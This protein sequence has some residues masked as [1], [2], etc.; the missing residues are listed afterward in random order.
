MRDGSRH[1]RNR[2]LLLLF[3]AKEVMAVT[4]VPEAVFGVERSALSSRYFFLQGH[5][6][7][8]GAPLCLQAA[9][10]CLLKGLKQMKDHS[11]ISTQP[12]GLCLAL[13]SDLK[14]KHKGRSADPLWIT[15]TKVDCHIA[16]TLLE[17]KSNLCLSVSCEECRPPPLV[18]LLGRT[19]LSAESKMFYLNWQILCNLPLILPF[20]FSEIFKMCFSLNRK[21]HV[22]SVLTNRSKAIQGQFW[23]FQATPPLLTIWER[24]LGLFLHL[25]FWCWQGGKVAVTPSLDGALGVERDQCSEPALEKC[26]SKCYRR[27]D[28]QCSIKLQM[29]CKPDNVSKYSSINK[30]LAID[31][32]MTDVSV[33]IKCAFPK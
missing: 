23:F 1:G 2:G 6:S 17:S 33:S 8:L 27:H 13:C 29:K 22:W 18:R 16:P 30:M 31:L 7:F 28:L 3:L 10:S 21:L 5:N 11:Q 25:S 4:D 12:A 15:Q 9:L 24:A 26:L 32:L 14:A 19:A 20:L